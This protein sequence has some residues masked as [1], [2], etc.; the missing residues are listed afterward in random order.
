LNPLQFQRV[1]V[2]RP[3][4]I[5]NPTLYEAMMTLDLLMA[6]LDAGVPQMETEAR[7]WPVDPVLIEELVYES[8]CRP[9]I[10]ELELLCASGAQFIFD[11]TQKRKEKK[12]RSNYKTWK[13]VVCTRLLKALCYKRCPI[14]LTPAQATHIVTCGL[15]DLLFPSCLIPS[16]H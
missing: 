5:Q 6:Q 15:Q 16:L 14:F 2:H 3:D 8:W 9:T 10:P 4:I 7:K 11:T 1:V 13:N 12:R